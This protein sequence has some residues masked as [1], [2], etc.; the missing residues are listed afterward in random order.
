MSP[1]EIAALDEIQIR[2]K[3]T[4]RERICEEVSPGGGALTK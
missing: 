1:D 3:M 4:F 2:R